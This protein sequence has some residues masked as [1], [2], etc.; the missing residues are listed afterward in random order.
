MRLALTRLLLSLTPLAAC[1]LLTFLPWYNFPGVEEL[2]ALGVF[3]PPAP[4]FYGLSVVLYL[5]AFIGCVVAVV[6][7]VRV[8]RG[9][10]Q[11][12][13]LQPVVG[14]AAAAGFWIGIGGI[15][16]LVYSL[17]YILFFIQSGGIG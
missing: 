8:L 5:G 4:V 15:L 11:Q 1:A 9:N 2:Y 7:G 3:P 16:F 10:Q 17:L 14:L 12:P 6:I 13:P